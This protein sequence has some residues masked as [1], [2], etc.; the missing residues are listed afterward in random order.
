MDC[1][2]LHGP[3]NTQNLEL[4]FAHP[5]PEEMQSDGTQADNM[6]PGVSVADSEAKRVPAIRVTHNCS[7]EHYSAIFT[8]FSLKCL[9][10]HV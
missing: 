8:R 6:I 9:N 10:T 4:H 1:M 2:L 7:Q 3:F 5:T